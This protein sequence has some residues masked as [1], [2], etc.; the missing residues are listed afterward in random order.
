MSLSFCTEQTVKGRNKQGDID[1]CS[2]HPRKQKKRHPKIQAYGQPTQP[3]Y[4][5]PGQPDCIMTVYFGLI[6]KK[7]T[8]NLYKLFGRRQ[9]FLHKQAKYLSHT[10]QWRKSLIQKA[11][12]ARPKLGK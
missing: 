7:H 10:F 8:Q 12:T 4:R 5:V 1:C 6:K 3:C 11:S 2:N 9:N